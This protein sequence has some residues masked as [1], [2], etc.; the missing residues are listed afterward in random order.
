MRAKKAVAMPKIAYQM[1]LFYVMDS[2]AV[3]VSRRD[4]TIRITTKFSC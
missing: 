3:T 2:V 1:P 4:G